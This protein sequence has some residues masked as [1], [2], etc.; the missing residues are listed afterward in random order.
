MIYVVVVVQKF[1]E[2]MK[3]KKER[4]GEVVVFLSWVPSS[5]IP[6]R[7]RL[8]LFVPRLMPPLLKMLPNNAKW[9]RMEVTRRR[10]GKTKG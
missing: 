8:L 7:L 1:K 3:N 10:S 6:L 4:G 5:M 2:K 9:Q